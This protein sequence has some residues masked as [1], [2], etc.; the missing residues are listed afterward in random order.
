MKYFITKQT[1]QLQKQ[2][3]TPVYSC[4]ILIKPK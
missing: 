4:H 2:K 1:D 3:V